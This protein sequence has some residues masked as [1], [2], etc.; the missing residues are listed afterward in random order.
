MKKL[1]TFTDVWGQV[2][3]RKR[4]SRRTLYNYFRKL[5]IK[6][7]GEIRQCP[8]FYPPDTAKNILKGLGL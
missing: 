7:V 3:K 2:Q 5:E 1:A 8:Q 4:V 6:P